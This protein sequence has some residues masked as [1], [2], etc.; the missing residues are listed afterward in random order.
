MARHCI[1]SLPPTYQLSEAQTYQLSAAHSNNTD[2]SQ[3]ANV[4]DT[5]PNLCSNGFIVCTSIEIVMVRVDL[6]LFDIHLHTCKYPAII[7]TQYL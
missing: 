6:N 2:T 4:L 1:I 3:T 7:S 5:S